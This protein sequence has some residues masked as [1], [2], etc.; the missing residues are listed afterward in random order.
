MRNLYLPY[1]DL[2][3][4]SFVDRNLTGTIFSTL[5]KRG[6]AEPAKNGS[7]Q[8]KQVLQRVSE[9]FFPCRLTISFLFLIFYLIFK[10]E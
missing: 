8:E 5:Q 10:T 3:G 9:P 7:I 2:T 6:T 4:I 1:V